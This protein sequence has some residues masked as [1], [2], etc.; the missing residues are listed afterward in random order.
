M[1]KSKGPQKQAKNWTSKAIPHVIV[2][3]LFATISCI[4]F[5]P[6]LNG[7][8][9]YQSD[10]TQV[11]GMRQEVVAYNEETGKVA[12]WTNSM[13][14][15][16]PT[17]QLHTPN[18]GNKLAWVEDVMQLFIEAPIGVFVV[19]MISAYILFLILGAGPWLAA[20]G[21][22][23]FALSTNNLLLYEAGHTAKTRALMFAPLMISG[24][25]MT[26]RQKYL[27]G[28]TLFATGAG[29]DFYANHYQMTYYILI[30]IG[31][32]GVIMLVKAIREKKITPFLIA[33]VILMIGTFL[34]VAAT[35]SKVM[36][37]M[38]YVKDTM[39]GDPILEHN[40]ASASSSSVTE[41]LAW[42][43]AMVWS[44]NLEDLVATIIPRAAG[45]SSAEP[46]GDGSSFYKALKARGFRG[47]VDDIK[48]PLYHGQQPFTGGPAYFGAV[49]C[50]LFV[51]G[52]FW[53][54]GNLRWWLL[55]AVVL[56][57]AMSLGKHFAVFN[58]LLFDFLP[59]YNKFRA[60]SSILSVTAVLMPI[61]AV[62]GLVGL[63]GKDL[64]RERFLRGLKWSLGIT[65]GV[66]F[67][68]LVLGPSFM[69]F[70][71]L[72]DARYAQNGFPVE[73]IIEDR[74]SYLRLDALR[75]LLFIM[76]TAGTVWLYHKNRIRSILLVAALGCLT[77]VDLWGIGR[78]YFN[79]EDFISAREYENV[80]TKDAADTEILKDPDIHYRVHDLT[81]DPFNNSSRSYYHKTIGGYHAA[82]LQRYQDMI[83]YYIGDNHQP[84]LNM[85]NTKYFIV[86]D[87][88]GNAVVRQNPGALGN[89]WF[90][91][92]VRF[93]SSANT[94]IEAIEQLDPA[95][96]AIVHKDFS[97]TIGE[98]QPVKGGSIRLTE[99]AP[100]KLVYHSE[101]D[102]EQFAVFSEVWY[103]PDKGW[104]AY[105]DGNP[106]DHIRVNYIL[107][108]MKL[109]AGSHTIEF[110]F[111]PQVYDTGE[112]IS[113]IASLIIL[114]A[115]IVA[116]YVHFRHN[117]NV[118]SEA[119][120][121]KSKTG[122][123]S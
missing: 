24:M 28:G 66:V 56:T 90:V 7:K 14:G 6:Q 77:L 97:A 39:R 57:M 108:G 94:E 100:D 30:C 52:L 38:Q 26:Y 109:P 3:A 75:S 37:S 65:G 91:D 107:R 49:V 116:L 110:V 78:R 76:L 104:Q 112:T 87:N 95:T 10:I 31:I 48:E 1:A 88:Q 4:F 51:C 71:G 2:L 80:F 55:I 59:Y 68:V 103:G 86:P 13:F 98:F 118:R 53:S 120:E 92:E 111:R 11:R 34:A 25:I 105:L 16:M 89:A 32:Y 5:Y 36:V 15:G 72:N 74:K 22:I 45:G 106:T 41:G 46:T 123:T 73:E 63:L 114:L 122:R 58:R 27:L 17:F 61:G 93:V 64:S 119:V 33:S 121:T 9:L 18:P 70:T 29:L 84:T 96:T 81:T 54:T 8:L 69:D 40:E 35:A 60:P 43:Y 67:A 113:L 50:F 79:E 20:V 44:N 99:Y 83:D 19:G 47:S 62:L 115:L 82:K 85:L 102:S 21:A 23:A 42:D 12:L 101:S 117:R